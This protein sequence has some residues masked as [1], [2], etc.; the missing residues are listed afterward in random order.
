MHAESSFPLGSK[1][2]FHFSLG[3][4]ISLESPLPVSRQD[5][6]S[7]PGRKD[8]LKRTETISSNQALMP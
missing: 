5:F 8:L 1:L 4:V 3:P 6:S 7:L 2:A